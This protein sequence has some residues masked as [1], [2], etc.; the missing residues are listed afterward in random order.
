MMKMLDIA[1]I[2]SDPDLIRQDLKKRGSYEKLPLV[3]EAVSLDRQ[4]RHLITRVNELRHRRNMIS[5][6]IGRLRKKGEEV[7]ELIEEAKRLPDEL[8]ELEEKRIGVEKRLR[9]IL[10]RLPNILHSSVPVGAGEE[11]N[12]VIRT[13]GEPPEFSHPPRDHIDLGL[14]LNL[15]DVERAGKVAGSRFYY[16]RGELVRLNYALIKFALD[17]MVEKGF[18]LY[19]PPYM[20]R[21]RGVESA[22]DLGD[23]EDVIYK[24]EEEDLYLI[25]T[26][27]FALL[28]LHLDEILET[29]KLPLRYSG[30][31]PCFRKEAGTHGRDTKGI[32]R[33]H[34]FEK[35]EQFVFSR[36]ESSWEE[37]ERLI[38]NA[39]ELYQKLGIPHRVVNV[40]TGDIGSIAAKKYDL[41]A[42]LPGQGKYREMVSC[43]NCTDYQARR[44]NIRFRP[45]PGKP[46]EPVHTLNSTLVATERAL[47]AIMEN[48]QLEDGTIKVPEVL[49]PYMNGIEV[50]ERKA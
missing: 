10:Y 49:V 16:L 38:A 9:R 18:T 22:T 44:A 11:D 27:E 12:V 19:Q 30:I 40:C 14:G 41:E 36:P 15:I 46:T 48:Y 2:R 39:E 4:R 28:A 24:V 1:L 17:L 25:P 47:V 20:L 6:E 50:I 3:D 5:E 33:V 43:S 29:K 34:Q 35:V 31:S 21:R 37:H 13:W 32:F 7:S 42:W 23:F 45:E 8:K 26:S